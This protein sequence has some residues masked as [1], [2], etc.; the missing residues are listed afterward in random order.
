MPEF[1]ADPKGMATRASSGKTINALAAGLP[2]LIGGSADL[3]PSNNTWI[4]SSKD[5]QPGQYDGRNLHFGVRE[6][7]MGAIVNGMAV[8]GGVI[9]Y[10]ATFLVFSDYMRAAIR[11]SALSHYPPSGS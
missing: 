11:L 6:H 10:G 2:E 7:G 3:T 8:H 1:P 9:P 5:F 4:E